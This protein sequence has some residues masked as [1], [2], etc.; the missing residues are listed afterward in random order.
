MES[1]VAAGLAA[2]LQM[3]LQATRLPLQRE[4]QEHEKEQE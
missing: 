1:V 3:A 4:K 2:G